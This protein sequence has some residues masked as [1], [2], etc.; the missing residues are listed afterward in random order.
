MAT[1]LLALSAG[2]IDTGDLTTPTNRV[3]LELSEVAD[4]LAVVEAFSHVWALR[5]D[6]GLVVFDTSS[7]A[8]G[9]AAVASLRSWSS[10]PVA[11]H[12]LHP[13][14]PR[15]RR[16]CARLRGRRPGSR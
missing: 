2:I 3:N 5:T 15:P 1:D 14:P 7:D 9:A 11:H 13:R 6:A 4:G 16:W 10:D 8:L 12:R